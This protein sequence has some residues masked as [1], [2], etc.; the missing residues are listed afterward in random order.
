MDGRG[1]VEPNPMVGCILTRDGRVIGE[2]FHQRYGG[3]HAEP[4]A[5]AACSESPAGATAY[6]TL[7]PCCHTNKQTPPCA[8]RLIEA[9]VRRVVVGC[10]DPN[11]AVNGQ[12]VA[13]LRNGGVE[14]DSAPPELAA[15]FRQL[16]APFTLAQT[17]NRPYITLKWAQTADGYVAAAGGRPLR[18]TG[19]ESDSLV[20]RLRGRCHGIAVGV[21]TVISDNPSLTARHPHTA[22]H[23][24]RFIFDRNL[25]TPPAPRLLHDGGPE[26]TILTI[27]SKETSHLARRAALQDAGANIYDVEASADGSGYFRVPP[28]SALKGRHVLIEP[29]PTLATAMLPWID[30][31]WIFRSSRHLGDASAP[32]A[33]AVPSYYPETGRRKIGD[34]VLTEYLN[35]H[36]ASFAAVTPSADFV[37]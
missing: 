19:P 21:N 25:R 3:P 35:T 8:P 30:R 33:A 32:R 15:E 18:I 12:G 34:D 6:V 10:L 27:P 20:Q 37:L 28:L 36:A 23:P 9:R 22:H 13:M 14:V 1:H 26:T 29:G 2:G 4:T 11:P 5:L 31:L 17:H 7:E 16:I 24:V